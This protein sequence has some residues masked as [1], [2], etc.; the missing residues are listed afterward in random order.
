[1]HRQP[2]GSPDVVDLA[3]LK[4]AIDLQTD[5][6][7]GCGQQ[8]ADEFFSTLVNCLHEEFRGFL[9]T[10]LS[11]LQNTAATG[12]AESM[13]PAAVASAVSANGM[14]VSRSLFDSPG[15]ANN[16]EVPTAVAA[17]ARDVQL[18]AALQ[19]LL[20]T[21]R[22][23]HTEVRM[24]VTCAECKFLST[25]R[26]EFYRE[27]SIDLEA[28]V[29]H[30]GEENIENKENST[31]TK[32]G[33]ASTG[34]NASIFNQPTRHLQLAKLLKLFFADQNR[35][36]CCDACAKAGRSIFDGDAGSRAKNGSS[37][38]KAVVT[39]KLR[40]LPTTLVVHLKRFR[41]DFE[42]INTPVVFPAVLEITSDMCVPDCVRP[43]L[44]A[45]V[46]IDGA[47][48][49][50]W[51]VLEEAQVRT[52]MS[53]APGV[54]PSP[55]GRGGAVQVR[56]AT[57]RLSAVV[58]HQGSNAR[59]G[60]YVTDL[61]DNKYNAA[62]AGADVSSGIDAKWRRCDDSTVRGTSL[63]KVLAEQDT[64]YLLFYQLCEE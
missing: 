46:C 4:R 44:S 47:A 31:L 43:D 64:P 3:A 6:F 36:F 51:D 40:V 50:R 49:A 28:A 19:A 25:E 42:K 1:M 61:P 56:P 60:H 54:D 26:A 37:N 15:E 30:A 29:V 20:P 35:H 45:G 11:R 12:L 18:T 63:A 53:S 10:H 62:G 5:L 21:L 41:Y 2:H 59:S 16:G 32:T 39:N 58:R 24:R 57:Y 38:A 13:S 55:A 7:T 14:L 23:F 8:D 17:D 52:S 22:S 27:L 34:T 9:C 48:D 33:L